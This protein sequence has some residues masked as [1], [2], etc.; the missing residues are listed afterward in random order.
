M[1]LFPVMLDQGQ[2]AWIP[3]TLLNERRAEINHSQTLERL[4]QRGGLAPCE[5]A[6]IILDRE[7]VRMGDQE[8]WE[9]IWRAAGRGE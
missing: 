6:A 4:A 1:K 8:A 2:K 9:V 5:V 7:W 3:W